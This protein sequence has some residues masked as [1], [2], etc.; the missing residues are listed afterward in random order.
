MI[1]MMIMMI[2]HLLFFITVKNLNPKHGSKFEIKIS[3]I[4]RLR[5]PDNTK[6]GHFTL[7]FCRGRQRNVQRIITHVHSQ[8]SAHQFFCS[9]TFPFPL[10][11]YFRKLPNCKTETRRSDVIL[12]CRP[13]IKLRIYKSELRDYLSLKQNRDC[14]PHICALRWVFL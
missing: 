6:Y 14:E 8:C 2:S 10:P 4:S 13:F 11:S 5:S 7:L 1:M 9:V 3:K 12:A